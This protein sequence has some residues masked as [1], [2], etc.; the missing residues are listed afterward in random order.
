MSTCMKND[1]CYIAWGLT[2]AYELAFNGVMC[3][4]QQREG[5]LYCRPD[6]EPLP[7]FSQKGTI[8]H[9]K[10]NSVQNCFAILHVVFKNVKH[11]LARSMYFPRKM[12]VPHIS[13]QHSPFSSQELNFCSHLMHLFE[14][15]ALSPRNSETWLSRASLM[16]G[17]AI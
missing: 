7:L 11:L 12:F 4:F 14:V 13:L 3:L 1:K 8:C 2:L 10:R 16:N 17:V 15:C 9:Q 6:W 5:S